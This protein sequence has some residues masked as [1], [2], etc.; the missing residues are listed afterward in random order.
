MKTILF[1]IDIVLYGIGIFA[2]L[3]TF[4]V[5]G[6]KITAFLAGIIRD[7]P[8]RKK[9]IIILLIII[10]LVG[11]VLAQKEFFLPSLILWIFLLFCVPFL[12][13]YVKKIIH[14]NTIFSTIVVINMCYGIVLFSLVDNT[15]DIIGHSFI[16]QY[17]VYYQKETVMVN[18]HDLGYIDEERDIAYI[19]TEDDHLDY[20]LTFIF[21]TIHRISVFYLYILAMYLFINIKNRYY[22]IQIAIGWGVWMAKNL[23]VEMFL[24]GDP[25]TQ[26]IT[27]EEWLKAGEQGKPAWCYYANDH[28]NGKKYGKLYNW[29]AVND[30][31][32]LAPKGW[33]IPSDYEWTQ[34]IDYVMNMGYPNCSWGSG[35]TANALKS[36]RQDGRNLNDGN[37]INH[38]RWELD[39]M[40]HGI[41]KFGFSALPG[42]FRDSNGGFSCLGR[43]G[44]WWSNTEDSITHAWGR[45]MVYDKGDVSR[46]S[47]DK[48]CGISVRCLKYDDEID[49]L[50][51]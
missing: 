27:D 18:Y 23:N 37:T 28:A 51:P 42:G 40:H 24:N 33:H 36:S 6:D 9:Y 44:S 50:N 3:R 43:S 25:I 31:R 12:I 20:I 39:Q 30:P 19:N 47:T 22:A 13:F 21:P 8:I 41:D 15:R 49:S 1:I 4:V 26:A 10:L 32:G 46:S 48:A 35:G 45:I 2:V 16:P 29:F 7:F 5:D 38:P 11:T 14:F 17:S 34:L